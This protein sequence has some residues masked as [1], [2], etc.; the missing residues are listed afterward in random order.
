MIIGKPKEQLN[1]KFLLGPVFTSECTEDYSSDGIVSTGS[2][3]K[4]STSEEGPFV[5]PIYA[6]QGK[7]GKVQKLEDY[8]FPEAYCPFE[9]RYYPLAQS[10]DTSKNKFISVGNLLSAMYLNYAPTTPLTQLLTDFVGRFPFGPHG[11]TAPDC[12]SLVPRLAALGYGVGRI[13][14]YLDSLLVD[15]CWTAS[16]SVS[17]TQDAASIYCGAIRFR[18][19]HNGTL[20]KGTW[21]PA[22]EGTIYDLLF[23]EFQSKATRFPIE[24][25]TETGIRNRVDSFDWQPR[26]RISKVDL[27]QKRVELVKTNRALWANTRAIAMLLKEQDLYSTATSL[28]SVKRQ[29]ERIIDGL[30]QL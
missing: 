8:F 6:Y 5:V 19:S 20:G 3:L 23:Q 1:P 13:E 14:S 9:V 28:S 4:F 12:T 10:R 18:P 24:S 21:Y 30:R 27:A 26:H 2:A 11:N 17:E 25:L 7:N 16:S 29:V 22:K 15:V